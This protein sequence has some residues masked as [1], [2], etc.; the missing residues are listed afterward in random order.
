[1]ARDGEDRGRGDGS[2]LVSIGL[3]AQRPTP[4]L[5]DMLVHFEPPARYMY[6]GFTDA[7]YRGQRLHAV[8]ILNA[9]LELFDRGVPQ[10]VTL[11][12]RTNY[13]ATISVLRMGWQP[14]GVIYRIRAGGLA[15][16]GRTK[17]ARAIGMRLEE[18]GQ[19]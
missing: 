4:V 12:E 2:R 16:L 8:G 5:G 7:A 14:R 19:P 9:A 18:R 10:L 6:R 11:C 13:P 15:H 17:M 1:M 3:Y